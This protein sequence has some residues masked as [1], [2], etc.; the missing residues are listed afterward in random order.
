MKR[1]FQSGLE[2][3][4]HAMRES[5]DRLPRVPQTSSPAPREPQYAEC[6]RAPRVTLGPMLSDVWR[7]DPM[8]LVFVLARYKFVARMLAGTRFVAEIG[9]GD[10]FASEIVRV[11]AFQLDLYDFDPLFVSVAKEFHPRAYQ[12]DIVA[13]PLPRPYDAIFMLDVFEHIRPCDERVA[14]KNIIRSLRYAGD[15]TF[16]VGMPSI[17]SQAYASAQSRAGHV[18]CKPGGELRDLM[19]RYFRNVLLFGMNDE[20]VHTGFPPMCNYL[21]AVCSGPLPHAEFLPVSD[22]DVTG[23]NGHG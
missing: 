4:G 12:H 21:F 2:N 19:R 22:E 20:V 5:V 17:E 18:N 11:N 7:R 9:C 15:G 13:A 10:G 14:V 6:F 16:I 23:G 8:R 1:P 3:I